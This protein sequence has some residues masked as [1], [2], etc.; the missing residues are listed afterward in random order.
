MYKNQLRL[1]GKKGGARTESRHTTTPGLLLL[2]SASSSS[3]PS[4]SL[5]IIMSSPGA[6]IGRRQG[7]ADTDNNGLSRYVL[8][9]ETPA[10]IKSGN[11]P[12]LSLEYSQGTPNGVLGYSWALSGVSSIHLGAPKVV[13][14]KVNP[15]PPDYDVQKP[16][17]TLDGTDLLN[18]KGVYLEPSTEYTTEI[19]NT[20]L[21]ITCTPTNKGFIATD[22][23]GRVTEYGTTLDSRVECN[24]T[25]VEWR[26]KSQTD[27][28]G[29]SLTYYY[30]ASPQ[31]PSETKDVNVSYLQRIS[32]CSNSLTSAPATHVVT[33]GYAP[34][35]DLI[36]QTSQGSTMTWANI[37]TSIWVGTDIGGTKSVDR[38][39]TLTYG[40]SKT[41][42]DSCLAQVTESASVGGQAVNLLPTSFKYTEPDVG[43]N[44]LF[45]SKV[46]T[47]AFTAVKCSIGVVPL[48]MTGRALGD[49]AF[50]DWD[51]SSKVLTARTYY[52]ERQ[53]D[54]TVAWMPST[55]NVSLPLPKLDLSENGELPSFM[56]PDLRG[57]GRSDLIIPYQND[58]GKLAFFLSESTG[59]A[60]TATK[61]VK[62]TDF[63]WV[64][65]SKF[66]AMD[67]SGT[68]QVDVIQ[69][70]QNGDKL[71][72]RNFPGIVDQEGNIGLGDAFQTDTAYGFDNTIDWFLLRHPGTGA[73]SL[74]RVWQDFPEGPDKY[75]IKTTAFSCAKVFD[76]TGGF[77]PQGVSSTISNS[78]PK[79]DGEPA[80]SVM[81]C[82]INGDG[83]QDVVLGRAKYESPNMKFTFV[84]AIANG[85]GGFNLGEEQSPDPVPAEEP[86]ENGPAAFSV[87]NIHGG[88][89]PSLAYAY[90][91]KTSKNIVCLSVGGRA[92][93][94][95]SAVDTFPVA[96]NPGFDKPQVMPVDLNGTGMGGWLLFNSAQDP[97]QVVAVYNKSKPTDLLS[98]AEDPM[99]LTTSLAYGCLADTAVY[100]PGV[101]WRTYQSTAAE[102]HILLGA[103]NHVVTELHHVNNPAINELAFDVVIKK[104]YLQARINNVGRGWLGFES[105]QTAN[106][107]DGILTAE[108]FF[109]PFP[110]TGL[111]CK[112]DTF[113]LSPPQTDHPLSSKSI[114]YNPVLKKTDQWNVYHVDKVFDQ[115]ETI[116][117][118]P[119]AGTTGRVQKTTFT[120]DEN[121]NVTAK[122]YLE[123]QNGVP[124]FQSWERCT[125][126]TVK[127][128]TGL[129][130]TKKITGVEANQ[131]ATKFEA[132]DVSFTKY[133]Y[134]D[135]TGNMLS[136]SDW[137][138]AQGAFLVTSYTFDGYGNE[139][140][141]IDPAGLKTETTY[142]PVFNNLVIKRAESAG[143][144]SIT[145]FMAYDKA[146]G[147]AVA[148][149][150]S[151]GRLTCVKVDG[152][153]R[154]VETR[155]QSISPGSQSVPANSFLD[156]ATSVASTSFQNMLGSSSTVL[157]PYEQYSYNRL[158]NNGKQYLTSITLSLYNEGPSGQTQILEAIDCVGHRRMRRSRQGVDPSQSPPAN[159]SHLVWNYWDY[160]SRGNTAFESFPIASST[161]AWNNFQYQPDRGT[162]G[163]TSSFDTLGRIVN[164][165]RPSHDNPA[166][167][168]T[169]ALSYTNGG[170]IVTEVVDGPSP[171]VSDKAVQ[172]WNA[173]RS[174]IS[175][176]GKEHVIASTNQDGMV[177]S[178]QYDVAGNV[179]TATDPSN[180]IE[181]RTY[182]SLGQLQTMDNVYQRMD[183]VDPGH[184]PAMTYVYDGS[185]QLAKT[186]SIN[187]TVITFKRDA[188]GRPLQK[189]GSGDGKVLVYTYDE[190]GRENLS[191]M[192]VYPQGTEKQLESRLDFD[193]DIRG[194]LSKRTLTLQDG[195]TYETAFTYDWQDQPTKKTY[196]NGAEKTNEYFGNVLSYTKMS[197]QP[198]AGQREVWLDGRYEY[199]DATRKPTAIMVG[200]A[201]TART[202]VHKLQYDAQAYPLNHALSSVEP[203][204]GQEVP[205]VQEAYRYTGTD[206]I[207][208]KT[209]VLTAT[210][211]RYNYDGKR[212]MNSQ[213][214]SG[215]VKSYAY[216]K[217]GNITTKGDTSI[218][219][220]KDS[221]KGTDGSGQ[222]AFNIAYDKSGRMLTRDTQTSSMSFTY[223][224]F[225][226]M[227]SYVDSQGRKTAIT[228][229]PDG[230]TIIRE[231]QPL[232]KSLLIVSDDYHVQ[233]Q[234][235][236]TKIT[237]LKLFGAG[238]LLASY[239]K[240]EPKAS[241]A[242]GQPPRP[243]HGTDKNAVVFFTDQKGSV[244][245][246]YAGADGQLLETITYDD[247]GSPSV[248]TVVT[249]TN[250]SA[251]TSTY[252]AMGW[253]TTSGLLDFSS[254]WYDPLVGRFTS[255]DDILDTAALARTDGLNRLAFENNDPINHN[256]PSGHWSLDSIIGAV[257]GAVAVGLAIGVTIA[258]GG[259]ATPLA[260]AA[261]G[262]LASGGIAGIKYSFDHKNERG[263]KFWAGYGATV[264]VN[265]AVGAAAGALGAVA[266][267]A[268]LVSA[269]G[270]LSQGASWG[271]SHSTVNFVGKAA[272]VGSKALIGATS[273]LVNTV[274]HNAVESSIYGQD[275]GLF[276]GAGMAA[277]TGAF[278]GGGGAAV[279][280][281]SVTYAFGTTWSKAAGWKGGALSIVAR[282][283]WAVV[284]GTGL[285]QK[286]EAKGRDQLREQE[287]NFRALEK[288]VGH[289]GLVGTLS[290][291]LERNALYVNYG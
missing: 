6:A 11:E 58:S 186:E 279:S 53:D 274:T 34:R 128:I 268:R 67:L 16:K 41:T 190:G 108:H 230:K 161:V 135:N 14:D 243:R 269:T 265:A 96:S 205:L 35:P 193:Y 31:I 212:L 62:T 238:I 107:T 147:Q 133:T 43:P 97:Q 95:V 17:L 46:S 222:A 152:F 213:I 123:T 266:S 278:L 173:P 206:Q 153:R 79:V 184:Q 185:G 248:Q 122:N 255:P 215:P 201:S 25:A 217:A 21:L 172:L 167:P 249:P 208:Q 130:A 103:P 170:G 4:T 256:D 277:L 271:L 178:F 73:A 273:S 204:T 267:P 126:V 52:A 51:V 165:S 231:Q 49:L 232:G 70:L 39:Y 23:M 10:G 286:A 211:T 99:G 9:I 78:Y 207:A 116:D 38:T 72:L 13:Y 65:K 118:V 137:F 144:L 228:S 242:T 56:T 89:Y 131:D 260:A 291:H 109:Q 149:L 174:Y 40:Q 192:S 26:I 233:T 19:N 138:D 88:L 287:K 121:S 234:P 253:D 241:S 240:A 209:D 197:N 272:A 54:Q 224:S 146:S 214:G 94:V 156:L 12:D 285:D 114:D 180:N 33:F 76:S 176:N 45:Q 82:D 236:G 136:E 111:K 210:T 42:G 91:Q 129:L 28:H 77:E 3:L 275:V 132:G 90:Q 83:A 181:K 251:R 44:D 281:K 252:E 191:S 27:R 189:S 187:G 74:V 104:K 93:G 139:A 37:L 120:V 221:A 169:S 150:E 29:N 141:S 225:G 290:N 219:Y 92:A 280:S 86:D 64:P 48:N 5:H 289:S 102:D 151:N 55:A 8:K 179:V 244:T 199:S 112:I 288:M 15:L 75:V 270:R 175:I 154:K 63:D 216:D 18:I 218:V 2:P 60:L 276:D 198:A 69:I 264:I 195:T 239:S 283:G 110:K 134:D 182:N 61:Q 171:N 105:I 50:M 100:E 247:F 168:V 101:D 117:A 115:V 124:L 24:N 113:P 196:P 254:R 119:A 203:S 143:S 163:T 202:F 166:V 188:K 36:K 125:Y 200:E 127:G 223:D 66:M 81:S 229:G 164:A 22:N 282:T 98:S 47:D 263:G 183:G 258:T 237:T 177:S 148:H 7:K 245:R 162:Q 194:R 257:I 20:G 80:W 157:D 235:D 140:T 159:A 145:E 57:D 220:G 1:P 71:S 85:T 227:N 160:D 158:E 250:P 284:Q 106:A 59:E 30:I 246:T 262:A 32:Y 226:I 87:S 142:D 84:V 261:V 68:G 155:L 259:A